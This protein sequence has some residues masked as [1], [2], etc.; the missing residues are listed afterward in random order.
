MLWNFNFP[1]KLELRHKMWDDHIDHKSIRTNKIK[2]VYRNK[3]DGYNQRNGNECFY[4]NWPFNRNRKPSIS[5]VFTSFSRCSMHI[6]ECPCDITASHDCLSLCCF[7]CRSNE[8]YLCKENVILPV[9]EDV[10]GLWTSETFWVKLQVW[11]GLI[12]R[13][14][15]LLCRVEVAVSPSPSP[16]WTKETVG[17]MLSFR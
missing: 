11:A 15:R 10:R 14:P 9:D 12:L 5:F 4:V 6:G 2:T 8:K 1:S 3:M 13:P 7:L 16:Y 17:I